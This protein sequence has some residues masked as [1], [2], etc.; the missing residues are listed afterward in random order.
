M[1]STKRKADDVPS[2]EPVAKKAASDNVLF[3]KLGTKVDKK[4]PPLADYPSAL[5]HLSTM[6][7][8]ATPILVDG[9]K[10]HFIET[11]FSYNKCLV[12]GK[13]FT[14]LIEGGELMFNPFKAKAYTGKGQ[15]PMSAE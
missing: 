2:D 15:M 4:D 5:S 11:A 13:N 10:F 14:P 12:T 6:T 3:F 7:Y 8:F 9:Q 1:A